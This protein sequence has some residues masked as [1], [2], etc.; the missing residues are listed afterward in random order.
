MQICKLKIKACNFIIK[1]KKIA[2]SQI[3][4][5]KS[6]EENKE[7][8]PIIKESIE[9]IAKS[10]CYIRRIEKSRFKIRF[11]SRSRISCGLFSIM[12]EF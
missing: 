7:K 2:I 12:D 8:R 1:I 5:I 4:R 10:S 9:S 11:Q 3:R 6:N